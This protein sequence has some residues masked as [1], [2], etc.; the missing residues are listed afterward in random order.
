[1]TERQRQKRRVIERERENMEQEKL[2][3]KAERHRFDVILGNDGTNGWW[4]Q[5]N[6]ASSKNSISIGAS[7]TSYEHLVGKLTRC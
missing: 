5:G 4:T 6:E 7:R 1:M 3:N 2:A